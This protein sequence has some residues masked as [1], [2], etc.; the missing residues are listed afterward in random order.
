M[1]YFSTASLCSLL[2]ILGTVNA[3]PAE[4]LALHAVSSTQGLQHRLSLTPTNKYP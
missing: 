4:S 3:A 2:T 1:V